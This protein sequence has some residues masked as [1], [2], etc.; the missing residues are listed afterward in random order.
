MKKNTAGQYVVGQVVDTCN[1]V[2]N[3]TFTIPAGL[4]VDVPSDAGFEYKLG[5]QFINYSAIWGKFI[6]SKDMYDEAVVDLSES[7]GNLDWISKS[8]VPFADPKIDM[9]IVTQV[10]G[11]MKVDGDYLYAEDINNIKHYASFVRGTQTFRKFLIC[12]TWNP[13]FS[14]ISRNSLNKGNIW[15]LIPVSS[16]I[17]QR[18]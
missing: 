16:V 5:V 8:N 18:I 6:R 14:A 9:Y 7:W 13:S 3:F 1:F 11:A 4:Q 17:L 2:I 15:I 10:A 12:H